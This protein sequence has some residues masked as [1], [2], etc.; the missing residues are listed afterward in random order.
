MTTVAKWLRKQADAM[1][2]DVRVRSSTDQLH[3]IAVQGPLSRDILRKII[4]TPPAQPNMDELEWFKFSI[5]RI[6]DHDGI[7]VMVSRTG[8]SGELGYEIFCHPGDAPAVW[9]R[10]VGGRRA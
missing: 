5:G 4:W 1:G 10:C 6:G 9:G 8:Y 7:P 3:N 2:L